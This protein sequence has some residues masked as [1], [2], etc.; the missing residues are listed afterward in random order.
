MTGEKQR[1]YDLYGKLIKIVDAT[2][3]NSKLINFSGKTYFYDFD[4]NNVTILDQNFNGV[5]IVNNQQ[6][7]FK[8]KLNGLVNFMLFQTWVDENW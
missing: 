8:C 5:N 4:G 7:T 2:Y 1:R 6:F 3:Y